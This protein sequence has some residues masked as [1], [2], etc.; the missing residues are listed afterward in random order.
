MIPIELVCAKTMNRI[1]KI[2]SNSCQLMEE[3]FYEKRKINKCTITINKWPAK[4]TFN[5][6]KVVD[7]NFA[8]SAG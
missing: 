4:K 5:L 7:N 1:F 8:V 2:V 3:N 6:I